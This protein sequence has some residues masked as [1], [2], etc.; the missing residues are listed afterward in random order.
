MKLHLLLENIGGNLLNG[1]TLGS[2]QCLKTFKNLKT[3][4][5]QGRAAVD[6]IHNGYIPAGGTDQTFRQLVY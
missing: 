2:R 5:T 3:S 4:G 1:W 6:V